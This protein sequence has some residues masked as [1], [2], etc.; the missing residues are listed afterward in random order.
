[1][2]PGRV[3]DVGCGDGG[4]LSRARDAGWEGVGFDYESRMVAL[5]RARGVEVHAQDF[6]AFCRSRAPGEFDA[7]TLFDVLEHTP[8]PAELLGLL[9]PLLKKAGALVITLPNSRRPL[10]FGREEH[11]YPPH[12]FTRWSPE[13]LR[14]FLER[15][16]FAVGHLDSG[17]LRLGHLSDHIFF[18]VLMP[19]VLRLAK[20]SLFGPGSGGKTV[21]EHYRGPSVGA[22]SWLANPSRRQALV[23]A[24]K[25]A[26]RGVTFPLALPMWAYYRL[27]S[28]GGGDYLYALAR[29]RG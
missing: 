11:D 1:M 23:D 15:N 27:T 17:R 20:R 26:L 6:A 4:F 18:Y 3:L 19:G 16:S 8:E 13:A 9:R 28:P 2:P 7:I 25:S 12:H 14:G 10:P 21:A 24:A 22:N 5:A 29:R